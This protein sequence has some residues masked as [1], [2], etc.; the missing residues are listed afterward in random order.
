MVRIVTTHLLVLF[1][2]CGI[3]QNIRQR[4]AEKHMKK[5]SHDWENFDWDEIKE[6]LEGVENGS[7]TLAELGISDDELREF[8][9]WLQVNSQPTFASL[10]LTQVLHKAGLSVKD[11][12]ICAGHLDILSEVLD[13]IEEQEKQ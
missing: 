6:N 12:V 9:L 2:L 5:W 11:A 10:L 3:V 7:L 13:S 4:G 1:R 8:L